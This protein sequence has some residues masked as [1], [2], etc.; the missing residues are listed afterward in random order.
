MQ[1]LYIEQITP[2]RM[3][4]TEPSPLGLVISVDQNVLQRTYL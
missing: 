4:L 1:S 2:T 3:R